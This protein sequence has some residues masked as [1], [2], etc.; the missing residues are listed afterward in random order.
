VGTRPARR[1]A[2][3][4]A[5]AHTR[6]AHTHARRRAA[7]YLSRWCADFFLPPI[8]FSFFGAIFFFSFFGAKISEKKNAAVRKRLFH[9]SMVFGKGDAREQTK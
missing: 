9:P 1:G 4:G 2:L 7:T 6:G 5:H 3:R 8:F